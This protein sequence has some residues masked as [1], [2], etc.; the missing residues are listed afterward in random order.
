MSITVIDS[1]TL[2]QD[3]DQHI[4][5][6][7]GPGA[8]KTTWLINH[9]RNVLNYS[10][11]LKIT[12]KIACIT[13][14]NVAVD[15]IVKRLGNA[16]H[17]VEVSTIHSF[18]YKHLIKPYIH[19]IAADYSFNVAKMKGHDDTV[20]SNYSFLKD[21]KERTKQQRI[22][23]DKKVTDA[24]HDLKWKLETN[25]EFTLKPEYPVRI[26]TFSITNDSYY[27]YKTMAWEKGVLHHDDVLY[28]SYQ[29][30]KK[31]PFVLDVLRAKFPYF[32][33]DEFQDIH[34]IQLFIVGELAK[35]ETKIV[36]VGDNA[37]S[38][39]SFMGALYGQFTSFTLPGILN[40]EIRDN[41][42]S[43]NN[44]IDLLNIIRTD[45]RQKGCR[46]IAGE[47]PIILVGD[48]LKALNDARLKSADDDV[49]TLSR[50]NFLSNS[51]RKG[52]SKSVKSDLLKELEETDSNKDRKNAMMSVIKAIE[53]AQQGYFKDALKTIAREFEVGGEKATQKY[54]LAVL[55]K[56]LDDRAIF[57]SGKLMDLYIYLINS[58][59]KKLSKFSGPNPK[60]FYE[61]YTYQ[62]ISTAVQQLN[63]ATIHRTIHKAKGDEFNAVL[64]VIDA[65]KNG[66][67]DEVKELAF[68]LKPNLSDEEHRIRYVALSRAQN[69]LFI[70]VP[71]ISPGNKILMEALNIIVE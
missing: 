53:F 57:Q 50:N 71:S 54:A 48:K 44:I 9:I 18:L 51:I 47:V 49:C 67:F 21:W 60:T 5:V 52:L 11:R 1:K 30:I 35:K 61:T 10:D 19:F 14:T 25:G 6:V 55:K 68:I 12:R 45:I 63:E 13:Y 15:T 58:N 31:F 66:K 70:N 64:L 3:F 7:A 24:L 36:A 40:Y 28:F 59:L 16:V 42:R 2:V 27:T 39:Y 17:Q 22:T 56:L 41:W 43:T 4:K 23:D 20:L 32:F 69:F 62:E 8:G 65:D 33:I 34:P 38:I 37:Q 46:A 26:G 29:L